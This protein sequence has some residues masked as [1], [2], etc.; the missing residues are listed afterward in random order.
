MTVF[1]FL[2]VFFLCSPHFVCT[3]WCLCCAVGV[4][5]PFLDRFL[6][7]CQPLQHLCYCPVLALCH[8]SPLVCL[9][10]ARV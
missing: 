3:V 1:L 2:F 7:P 6:A 9:S 4:A 8:L 10:R 5:L